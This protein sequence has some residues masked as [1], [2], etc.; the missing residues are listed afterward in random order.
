MAKKSSPGP[1]LKTA[2]RKWKKDLYDPAREACSSAQDLTTVSGRRLKELYTPEDLEGWDF[3]RDLGFPGEPPYVRGVHPTMYHGR[4]WTM[5]QFSG[6]GTAEDTNRRYKY[7]LSHGQTGLSVAFHLPTLM[8]L[9]SDHPLAKGEIGKCGVA[10]DSLRDMEVLFDGIPLDKITTSM[11]INAPAA[12]LWAMYIA[13]A[14]KQGVSPRVISGTIQN[15]ILKEYIAQKTFIFPP[16]ALDEAHRRHHRIRRRG[17]PALEHDLD[18]RLPHPGSGRDG[19]PGAGLHPARR[20]RICRLGQWNA[21]W[22]WT[23]LP[24]ACPF[25]ST[26]TTI[27]SR[28]SPS[29]GPPARSG[30]RS[31]ATGSGRASPAP[32]GC[33]S[34]PR[35]RAYR[36]WPSSRTTTSSG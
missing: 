23:S 8:G 17:G 22:R 25:S 32:G 14:E 1:D 35:L 16:P 12:V 4:A 13:V 21:G 33:A 34:T 26:P 28:R 30:P 19:R 27:S 24:R 10:V 31:C 11:T 6:F 7:L 2:Y 15:D 18:L 20:H 9:D 5:R 36:S 29:T 3:S